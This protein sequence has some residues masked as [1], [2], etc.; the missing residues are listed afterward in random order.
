[1]QYMDGLAFMHQLRN[2]KQFESAPVIMMCNEGRKEFIVKAIRAG[3]NAYL[4]KPFEP[5][6]LLDKLS[7]MD[8]L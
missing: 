5:Q 6:V 2:D 1:M 3:A 7:S 4:K 8:L